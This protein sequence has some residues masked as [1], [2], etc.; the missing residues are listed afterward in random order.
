MAEKCVVKV[1]LDTH[2]CKL[3]QAETELIAIE[4]ARAGYEIVPPDAEADVYI[5]N[6]CT[7]THTADA[8]ARKWLRAAHQHSPGALLVACGCYAQRAAAELSRTTGA[9]L[10]VGNEA[11]AD[12][13]RLVGQHLE[14]QPKVKRDATS[15]YPGDRRT[16][17]LVKIQDGCQNFCSYC[18][19]PVVRSREVSVAPD[20]LS[21][22][23]RRRVTFGYREV[24]LTGTRIGS[25][26]YDGVKLAGLIERIL[27]ETGVSR[28]RLSSLQPQEISGEL[29]DRWSDPRL[30]RH[31][32]LSLQSG[33][34]PV[35]KRMKRRYTTEDYQH[36]L[37]LIRERV[38]R[39]AITTD[40]IVGFPGE[41]EAEF[42]ES[43]RFS[44][45]TGFARIHVFPYSRREGTAA[46]EMPDQV[47]DKIKNQRRQRMLTL[48][49]ESRRNFHEKFLGE[50]M[51][52]LWEQQNGGIWSG[53]TDNYINV[54]TESAKDLSNQLLPTRL[55]EIRGDGVWGKVTLPPPPGPAPL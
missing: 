19:V 40:I 9:S 26:H 31:F 24:V 7:V 12:L 34:D 33:S 14:R 55:T 43:Y 44:Q 28:L 45:E 53:L 17:T 54:Y 52:V 39:A 46:A 1:A 11:K 29:L 2:G 16:R 50:I 8:K 35:L 25:Y 32:H 47:P 48:A 3:N 6:T 51:E 23:I 38:P 36:T 21:G 10:I 5:L 27:A 22:E 30:C 49:K 37:S 20:T 42:E 13:L 41:T 18:I 15:S 4:F